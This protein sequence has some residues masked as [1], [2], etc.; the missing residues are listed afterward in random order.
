LSNHWAVEASWA[1]LGYNTS[2]ED[3]PGAE[4]WNSFGLAVDLSSINFGLVYKF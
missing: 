2:E 1:G 3:A 4:A